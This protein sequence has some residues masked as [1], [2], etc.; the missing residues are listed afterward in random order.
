[1]PTLLHA[2]HSLLI[3]RHSSPSELHAKLS[4]HSAVGTACKGQAAVV[5][6]DLCLCVMGKLRPEGLAAARR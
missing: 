5:S 3:L 2:P 6:A 4:V 1:M